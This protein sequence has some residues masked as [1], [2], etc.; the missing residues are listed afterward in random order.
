MIRTFFSL[1]VAAI[2]SSA[3]TASAQHVRQSDS[4]SSF[5]NQFDPVVRSWCNPHHNALTV[6]IGMIFMAREGS[7]LQTE[8]VDS[9]GGGTFFTQSLD[10]GFDGGFF[11]DTSILL[12]ENWRG[13]FC[14]FGVGN[15]TATGRLDDPN[16]LAQ[17]S[18]DVRYEANLQS[19]QWNVAT[20][21]TLDTTVRI[22]IRYLD[23]SDS[24]DERFTRPAGAN[25]D[26]TERSFGEAKNYMFGPQAGV[27]YGKELGPVWVDGFL[28]LA[29]LHN[30]MEQAGPA[31]GNSLVVDGV[32]DPRFSVEESD[33]TYSTEFGANAVIPIFERLQLRVGYRGLKLDDV[34]ESARQGGDPASRSDVSF[35]GATFSLLWLR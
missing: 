24:F 15:W 20:D 34:F 1:V 9:N 13:E 26:V 21:P 30:S 16:D 28:N 8:L 11:I 3:L 27:G 19:L 17:I 18:A 4:Q 14:Y 33:V 5:A 7:T 29:L 23:Y 2:A 31:Y 12:T 10:H 22:G 32:Q 6:D 35:H 25:P